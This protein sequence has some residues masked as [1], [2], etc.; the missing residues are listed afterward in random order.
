[1]LCWPTLSF[2]GVGFFFSVAFKR[3][4]ATGTTICRRRG[5]NRRRARSLRRWGK[6]LAGGVRRSGI[7]VFEDAPTQP[8]LH[9][10]QKGLPSHGHT[11][12]LEVSPLGL[13]ASVTLNT[14]SYLGS[15]IA[16][17]AFLSASLRV[18]IDLRFI[19]RNKLV[20]GILCVGAVKVHQR[21][22]HRRCD[23][24]GSLLT[25]LDNH[26]D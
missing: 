22:C 26:G 9:I 15:S 2:S 11:S 1:M 12:R 23:L 17:R 4:T 13:R 21:F 3:R 25:R 19:L 14:R 18:S 7:R 5:V 10:G 20:D 6:N 24:R 8:G 16:Q